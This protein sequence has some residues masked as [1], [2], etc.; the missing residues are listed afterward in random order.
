MPT[1]PERAERGCGFAAAAAQAAFSGNPLLDTMAMSRPP[2]GARRPP[3]PL[4]RGQIKFS[5]GRALRVVAGQPER[6]AGRP[7]RHVSCAH[8][9]EDRQ[10]L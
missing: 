8:R 6:S 5:R 7:D 9:L 1:A 3:Q 2:R 10:K 4:C